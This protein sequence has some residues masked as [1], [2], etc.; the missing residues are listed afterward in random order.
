MN[1][2]SFVTVRKNKR[3]LD[4]L[5]A[6]FN[7]PE[8]QTV[9]CKC[10]PLIK[11]ADMSVSLSVIGQDKMKLLNSEYRNK[12]TSTDV[13]SF[14]FHQDGVLGELYVSPDDIVANAKFL[15]HS[16]EQEFIE[17]VIHGLLHIT[18]YDHSQEMFSWQKKLTD[19]I[20]P[21]YEAYSR[22]R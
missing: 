14:E 18:G 4:R 17:I 9:F 12:P 5:V 20:L 8:V 15:G 2:D 3:L 10:P 16:F 19:D 7:T 22:A 13:L 11:Y 21:L 6:F 1:I